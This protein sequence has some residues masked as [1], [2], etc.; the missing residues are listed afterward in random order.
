MSYMNAL[1]NYILL[2]FCA[3][4]AAIVLRGYTCLCVSRDIDGV[5]QRANATEFGLAS[6]VFT[7]DINKVSLHCTS[8]VK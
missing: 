4:F 1:P 8:I 6:G 5:L 2:I 3:C 7:K